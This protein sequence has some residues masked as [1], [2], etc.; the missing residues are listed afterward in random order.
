MPVIILKK[1]VCSLVFTVFVSEMHMRAAPQPCAAA[2]RVAA[3]A[4]V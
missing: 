2:L 3:A 1:R 4:A